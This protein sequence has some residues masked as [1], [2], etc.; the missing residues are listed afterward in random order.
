MRL[1]KRPTR[2]C[3]HI[4][5]ER[6]RVGEGLL[7]KRLALLSDEQRQTYQTHVNNAIE[8]NNC[9]ASVVFKLGLA[10]TYL[11]GLPPRIEAI[12]INDYVRTES[13]RAYWA[14]GR[15]QREMT[16]AK[17]AGIDPTA[18]DHPTQNQPNQK[19]PPQN[20]PTHDQPSPERADPMQGIRPSTPQRDY[21]ELKKTHELVAQRLGAGDQNPAA[22]L[23]KEQLEDMSKRFADVREAHKLERSRP[24]LREIA[25]LARLQTKARENLDRAHGPERTDARGPRHHSAL[26]GVFS[27]PRAEACSAP[28]TT[29][30]QP[31]IAALRKA[32]QGLTLW[33][34]H[35]EVCAPNNANSDKE[36]TSDHAT[37]LS[38]L[39]AA[40]SSGKSV[41]SIFKR[42]D[43]YCHPR[44][45][46][47]PVN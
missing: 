15:A 31:V 3:R 26:G 42:P 16:R 13:D 1:A 19:Q 41:K 39:L 30:Q 24:E 12:Q 21:S 5:D 23:S 35:L 33:W 18:R 6:D 47:E 37:S 9:E 22:S 43:F 8:A 45:F 40:V 38:R 20:Q 10:G 28:R 27:K 25:E 29:K 11:Q 7:A 4:Q 32:P 17:L 36:R 34:G 2:I 46:S 14:N 44:M